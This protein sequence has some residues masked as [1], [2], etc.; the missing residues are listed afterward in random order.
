MPISR[1]FTSGKEITRYTTM[2]RGEHVAAHF[3][4]LGATRTQ[5]AST[6]DEVKEATTTVTTRPLEVL[7]QAL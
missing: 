2:C 6:L 7:Y 1:G 4:E 3:D 5:D